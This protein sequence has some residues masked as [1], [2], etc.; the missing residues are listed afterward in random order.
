MLKGLVCMLVGAALALGLTYGWQLLGH[1]IFAFPQGMSP[2]DP[3]NRAFLM[4]SM[5]FAA[6]AWTVLGFSVGVAVA[7]AL[8]NFLSDARWPSMFVAFVVVGAFFAT[9]TA[10]SHP[11]WF[12]LAG[13]VLP[14]LVGGVVS[15]SVGRRRLM[16]E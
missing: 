8:A 16:D 5:P 6:Q 4:R 7:G 11:L 13:V 2:L 14:L 15:A 10:M 3:N 1:M 9:L 12:Q